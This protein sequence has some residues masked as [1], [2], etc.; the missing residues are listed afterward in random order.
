VS[1][2]YDGGPA[3]GT[4]DR[5]MHGGMTLRDWF[6]GQALAGYLAMHSDPECGT[7]ERERTAVVCYQFADA[8]LAERAMSREG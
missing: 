7:P 2:P 3:F 5:T 8:M 4:T 1:K 6:A